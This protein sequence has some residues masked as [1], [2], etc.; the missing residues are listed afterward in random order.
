MCMTSEVI[1]V[2]LVHFKLFT[3]ICFIVVEKSIQV[4]YFDLLFFQGFTLI[5]YFF[6]FKYDRSCVSVCVLKI[7]VIYRILN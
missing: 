3:E 1:S 6:S 2:L 7:S 5:G 4:L